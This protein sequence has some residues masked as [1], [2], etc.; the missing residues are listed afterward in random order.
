[1]N[2]ILYIA[3]PP[4][5]CQ[6]DLSPNALSNLQGCHSITLVTL[7][8]ICYNL[9]KLAFQDGPRITNSWNSQPTPAP[10]PASCPFRAHLEPHITTSDSLS[11]SNTFDKHSLQRLLLHRFSIKFRRGNCFIYFIETKPE[12]QKN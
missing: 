1:M 2:V 11:L 10:S 3:P 9:S 6:W 5:W 12:N 4:R 8:R 7:S